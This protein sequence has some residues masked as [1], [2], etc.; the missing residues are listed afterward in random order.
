MLENLAGLG[1]EPLIAAQ[2]K[3]V[4]PAVAEPAGDRPADER[5][6]P[7]CGEEAGALDLG[8]AVIDAGRDQMRADQA[9]GRGAA[10][11]IAPG[12]R[13]KSRERTPLASARNATATGLPAGRGAGFAPALS[14]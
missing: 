3:P 10:D 14:P 7:G 5:E 12:D 2:Q 13:Q 6:D 4:I 11:E 9:V 1:L 8:E